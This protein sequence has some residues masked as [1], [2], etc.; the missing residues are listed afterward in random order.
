MLIKND[1]ILKVI[2]KKIKQSRLSQKFTQEYVSEHIDIS[3]D[4]LR[5]IENGRNVGSIPTLLNICNFLKI[6]PNYIFSELLTFKENTLD[7]SLISYI[8]TLSKEDRDLFKKI[9]IHIYNNY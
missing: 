4:L 2:G 7:T 6:S 5:N 8:N 3:I 1:D 9:I